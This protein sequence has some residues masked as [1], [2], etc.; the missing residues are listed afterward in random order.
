MWDRRRIRVSIKFEFKI[1]VK[2]D[3]SVKYKFKLTWTGRSSLLLKYQWYNEDWIIPFWGRR[4]N[5][6]NMQWNTLTLMTSYVS[7]SLRRRHMNHHYFIAHHHH[8]HHHNS[9]VIPSP[10]PPLHFY[11]FSPPPPPPHFYC[12]PLLH[13][14]ISSSSTTTIEVNVFHR[15]K[16]NSVHLILQMS[17]AGTMPFFFF[18]FLSNES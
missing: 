6:I 12:F 15:E 18:P 9:I 11:C 5:L 17:P 10:P 7:L 8:H 13:H 2:S 14:H 16:D 1:A 3:I 4:K